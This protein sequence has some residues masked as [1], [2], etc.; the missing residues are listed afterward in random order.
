MLGRRKL[1]AGTVG[2]ALLTLIAYCVYRAMFG[3]PYREYRGHG[4]AVYTLDYDESERWVASGG[5]DGLRIWRVDDLEEVYSRPG[6]VH[7]VAFL[8]DN[9]LM[10]ADAIEGILL[11]DTVTWEITHRLGEPAHWIVANAS[12]DGRWLAASFSIVPDNEEAKPSSH[13]IHV[14]R[15]DRHPFDE[16]K[17]EGHQGIVDAFAFH[18]TDARMTSGSTDGTVRLWDLDTGQQIAQRGKVYPDWGYKLASP[19]GNCVSA[20]SPDGTELLTSHHVS[21]FP[22]FEQGEAL[23]SFSYDDAAVA[24]TYSPDGKWIASGHR[25][26]TVRLWDA[27]TRDQIGEFSAFVNQTAVYSL[28][29]SADSSLLITA[30][31]GIMPGFNA[32]PRGLKPKD[33]VVR[34]WRVRNLIRR[35]VLSTRGAALP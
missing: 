28:R 9:R 6:R 7:A 19:G 5:E 18:P 2:V 3:E 32:L 10:C 8:D 30:G 25:D 22:E 33:T 4:A 24:G 27:S 15:I 12:R 23:G 16:L 17:L 13:D 20:F 34:V 29:F 1:I 26:A 31:K 35:E 14:W 21:P 11:L